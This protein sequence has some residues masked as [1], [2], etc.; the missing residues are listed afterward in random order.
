M[1]KYSLCRAF[2]SPVSV[3]QYIHVPENEDEVF[4]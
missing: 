4:L 3:I 1:K 2:T